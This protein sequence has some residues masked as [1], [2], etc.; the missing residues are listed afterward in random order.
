MPTAM[1]RF[2]CI[3][4]TA[5]KFWEVAEP[6]QVEDN[7]WIV[8]V[9]F[10]RIGKGHQEHVKAFYA[11]FGAR[12]YYQTKVTEKLRKGYKEAGKSKVEK[13]VISYTPDY[14][15]EQPKPCAHDKLSRKG[16]SWQCDSCKNKVEFDKSI[17][18]EEFE[19][20]AKVRRYFDRGVA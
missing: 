8:R 10:G 14:I 2:T 6:E 20:V 13:N 4:G 16:V 11:R 7:E 15:P 1:R 19:I 3:G 9:R 12:N 18:V 5:R 17:E